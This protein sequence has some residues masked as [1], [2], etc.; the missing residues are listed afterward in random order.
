MVMP[1]VRSIR[2]WVASLKRG[3]NRRR[4]TQPTPNPHQHQQ[5][6]KKKEQSVQNNPAPFD[7][8]SFMP[9]AW[10][11]FHFKVPTA[12]QKAM[13]SA[14]RNIIQV[15]LDGTTLQYP[16]KARHGGSGGLG[17]SSSWLSFHLWMATS[18]DVLG[19]S[20]YCASY[21]RPYDLTNF[22]NALKVA[23]G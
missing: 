4:S 18:S 8:P 20:G 14:K 23:S 12:I 3:N 16:I 15:E 19:G 2:K 5:Y 13:D 11:N 21:R 6:S 17:S 1:F 22:S 9:K 10:M 7:S